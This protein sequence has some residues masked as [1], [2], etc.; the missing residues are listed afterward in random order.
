LDEYSPRQWS[1]EPAPVYARQ[2]NLS[3]VEASPRAVLPGLD[4]RCWGIE[5]F[6]GPTARMMNES[7]R[8][9]ARQSDSSVCDAI[10]YRCRV[11]KK[12]SE[13]DTLPLVW[14]EPTTVTVR[15][16]TEQVEELRGGLRQAYASLDEARHRSNELDLDIQRCKAEIDRQLPLA[17]QMAHEVEAYRNRKLLRLIEGLR[18]RTNFIHHQPPAVQRWVDDNL[19][20]GGPLD[21]FLL[22]PSQSLSRQASLE[23]LLNLPKL[24]LRQISFMPLFDLYLR[25]GGLHFEVWQG[26]S[27]LVEAGFSASEIRAETPIVFSFPPLPAGGLVLRLSGKDL[28]VPLRIYEWQRPTWLGLG[29]PRRRPFVSLT[30]SDGV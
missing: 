16:E 10:L 22:R 7:D 12:P 17:R 25:Q 23:Y 18:D 1:S 19:L 14:I 26:E 15:R 2:D 5:F 13:A 24:G 21:R 30:F 3:G 4:L 27:R 29:R 6:Y 9:Q 20:F 8:R 11:V 28:D